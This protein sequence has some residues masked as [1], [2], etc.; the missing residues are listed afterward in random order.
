LSRFFTFFNV[1]FL[2][3]GERLFI[4]AWTDSHQPA[5]T[6][7][8]VKPLTYGSTGRVSWT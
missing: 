4:Y 3:W 6:G 2:F 1:F 7:K 8:A 5:A